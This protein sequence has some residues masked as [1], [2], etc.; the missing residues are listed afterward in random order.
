MANKSQPKDPLPE[1]PLPP[2]DFQSRT[3][4]VVES[5][6]VWYRLNPVRHESSLFFDR[7]GRGRFDGEEQGY[8]ILYVGEDEY[9]A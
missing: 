2:I 8:G 5:T 6:G 3:L 7:S 9:A 1:H 4:P